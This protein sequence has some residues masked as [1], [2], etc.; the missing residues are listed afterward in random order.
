MEFGKRHCLILWHRI[1]D[2][3]SIHIRLNIIIFKKK[4][5][6]SCLRQCH[7]QRKRN[8]QGNQGPTWFQKTFSYFILLQLLITKIPQLWNVF[9]IF[10]T[11]LWEQETEWKQGNIFVIKMYNREWLPKPNSSLGSLVLGRIFSILFGFQ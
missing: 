1:T 6:L 9:T 3:L 7:K 2:S 4:L 11:K 8:F 5:I 10:Y